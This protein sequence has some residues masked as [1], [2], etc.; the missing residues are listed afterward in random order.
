MLHPLGLPGLKEALSGIERAELVCPPDDDGVALALC[1]A[2]VLVTRRWN[3]RY[4]QPALRFVQ[5]LSSS[6]DQFDVAELGNSGVVLANASGLHEVASEH[7]IAL[8]LNLTREIKHSLTEARERR[9]NPRTAGEISGMTIVILGLGPIGQGIARRLEL[10]GVRIIGVT[11]TPDDHAGH[12][13]DVRPLSQL[14]EA[15][16][17]ASALVVAIPLSTVTRHIVSAE[18]LDALGCGY[19]VNVARGSVVDQAALVERLVNGRLRGAGLDVFEHEPLPVDSPLWSLPNVVAT[20]H[21]A[22]MA[23]SYPER[24]AKL[25]AHNLRALDG[26]ARWRNRVV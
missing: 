17:E 15:C 16:L 19:V 3:P 9:W 12:L 18:V 25:L 14:A 4:L 13:G 11:R 8:L 24:L 23:P 2:P 7:A 26:E 10:W 1:T 22:G 6:Y 5:A 20:P 21:M